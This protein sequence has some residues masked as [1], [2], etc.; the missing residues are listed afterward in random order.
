M[1]RMVSRVHGGTGASS[2]IPTHDV[3]GSWTLSKEAI[4]EET[5]A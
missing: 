3:R 2:Y 4:S 5:P 1:C